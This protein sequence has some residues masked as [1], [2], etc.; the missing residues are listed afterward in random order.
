MNVGMIEQLEYSVVWYDVFHDEATKED[1]MFMMRA[2]GPFASEPDA[3][4]FRLRVMRSFSDP[5]GQ[6][7]EVVPMTIIPDCFV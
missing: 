5:A 2:Y 4:D 7:V 3:T 1:H 6:Y